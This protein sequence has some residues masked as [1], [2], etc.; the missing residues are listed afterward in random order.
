MLNPFV[1]LNARRERRRQERAAFAAAWAAAG[2]RMRQE[3][4]E[5]EAER[6]R[7]DAEERDRAAAEIEREIERAA[8]IE[9]WWTER[10]SAVREL[11]ADAYQTLCEIE[12]AHGIGGHSNAVIELS[13]PEL[14]EFARSGLLPDRTL[15]VMRLG[16]APKEV[17]S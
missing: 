12:A 15:G 4:R 1:R 9:R 6:A 17:Q 13:G 10:A 7:L 5:I 2:E 11:P 3:A 16:A 8:A 14:R